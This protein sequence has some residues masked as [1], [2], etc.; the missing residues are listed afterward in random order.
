MVGDEVDGGEES[1]LGGRRETP[2]E[3]E[4]REAREAPNLNNLAGAKGLDEPGEELAFVRRGL[5]REP[6][7]GEVRSGGIDIQSSE[8]EGGCE[9][10]AG[11]SRPRRRSRLISVERTIEVE[12]GPRAS[13]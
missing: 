2:G 6:T 3:A 9:R 1:A 8:R 13:V 12:S 4:G 5:R 11:T 10:L 7:G